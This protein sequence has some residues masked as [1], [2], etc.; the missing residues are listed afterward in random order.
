MKTNR[1]QTE[2]PPDCPLCRGRNT[3]ALG[4][5]E[6]GKTYHH[7]G[8]CDLR[9]L[10]RRHWLSAVEERARY[11]MHSADPDDAGYDRFVQPLMSWIQC[12]QAP[13][14]TGL[15]FGAGRVPILAQ[16]L[17]KLG[18]KLSVYDSYFAP[19]KATLE[20]QFDFVVACEVVEHFF[21]PHTEFQRLFQLVRPGGHLFIQTHFYT[22][23]V[24]FL[25]WYY[26]RDPTHVVFYSPQTVAWIGKQFQFTE[27]GIE[28]RVARF[29]V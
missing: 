9:F 7:C 14:A 5:S 25:D 22:G 24:P 12:T 20:E 28:A 8:Q 17:V 10:A 23:E 6:D 26:R 11:E 13:P 15:D 1:I 2:W 18:Y 19:N 4:T 21:D 27:V 16:K 29:R 3:P